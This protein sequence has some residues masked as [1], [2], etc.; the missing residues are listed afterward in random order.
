HSYRGG[1]GRTT[2]LVNVAEELARRGRKVL[3]VD[4]DLES[5]SLG[6]QSSAPGLVEYVTSYVQQGRS[7]DVNE[8]LYQRQEE[9]AEGRVWIM[10]AGRQSAPYWGMLAGINWQQ[11][12]DRHDGYLFFE[13][14]REQWRQLGFDY[15]LIDTHAGITQYLGIATRQ[16]A[17][18]VIRLFSRRHGREEDFEAVTRQISPDR[19]EDKPTK[20]VTKIVVESCFLEADDELEEGYRRGDH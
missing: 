4:F 8:Y 18:A 11:L 5:P 13:D 3:L 9:S 16:L 19:A 10:P 6:G 14:T 1:I 12:Y 17:D 15:V 2:A 7:P 20:K